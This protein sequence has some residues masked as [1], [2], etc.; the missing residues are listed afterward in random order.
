MMPLK[1]GCS[2]GSPLPLKVMTS[3]PLP[4]SFISLSFFFKARFTA[5]RLGTP[6]RPWPWAFQPASQYTQSNEH[7]LP[8]L[9]MR[10]MPKEMPS[11]RLWMG[12]YTVLWNN[13]V[14]MMI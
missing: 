11:R 14:C 13:T 8:S 5:A 10:L 12:P 2:V 3:R 9:G 4:A 1:S 6:S 7:I